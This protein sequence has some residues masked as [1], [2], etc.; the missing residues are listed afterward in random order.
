FRGVFWID[1]KDE[2]TAQ[3]GFDRAGQLCGLAEANVE[4][5]TAWLS[6]TG[7]CWLLIID[8]ADDPNFDYAA[9]FPSGEECTIIV[10]TRNPD[11]GKKYSTVG[12][13]ALDQ[14]EPYL[15]T[16]LLLRAADRQRVEVYERE[17]AKHIVEELS[18]H[19]LAILHAGAYISQLCE[20][21]EYLELYQKQRDRLFKN[22]REQEYSTYGT[23]HATF[24]VSVEH[25]KALCS[26]GAEDAGDALDLLNLLAFTHYEGYFELILGRAAEHAQYLLQREDSASDGREWTLSSFH[27]VQLPQYSPRT[28][29]GPEVSAQ[30]GGSG[31]V[32][33]MH[34]LVHQWALERQD[35]SSRKNS[36]WQASS[37]LA[38]S[39]QGGREFDSVYEIVRS[40][41][42]ACLNHQIEMYVEGKPGLDVAALLL[43]LAWVQFAMYNDGSLRATLRAVRVH[44]KKIKGRAI[45]HNDTLELDSYLIEGQL[46]GRQGNT[47]EAVKMLKQVVAIREQTLP[48]THPD[49]LVSQHELAGAYMANGD[50]KRAA[51][52]L[53]HVVAIQEQTLPETHPR[54]LASQ[55]ELARAYMANG[56]NKRAAEMLEQVVAIK[57]QTLPE[58]HPRR[59]ASQHEL[60][61][62][63]MAN[64]DSKRAAEI[65]K[66]VV[67]IRE[68]TLPETHPNRLVSQH[69]LARAYMANGNSK[70]AAEMLEHVVAIEEQTLPETHPSRLASQYALARVYE[71]NG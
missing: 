1:C 27:A 41:V 4:S 66:H 57:E 55:H 22:K 5:V 24:E 54:R 44:L 7:D 64:G 62:A 2:K 6:S 28:A 65:F 63:Y 36:W 35:L 13:K 9:Y 34:P 15:A 71:L 33:S 37:A 47:K 3:A 61:R 39:C 11:S 70:R 67:A 50:N 60:A 42:R 40:H 18:R 51:E 29:D 10:T 26:K 58:T 8:N 52:M 53:E 21:N 31:T 43:Q 17:A 69:E 30:D 19:T 46:L 23:V 38:L 16:D 12:H 56:D 49:R 14:L 45:A 20:T 32:L 48:E 59:L 68:Q 25:L